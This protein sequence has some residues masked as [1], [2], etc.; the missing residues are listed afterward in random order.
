MIDYTK[1]VDILLKILIKLE[2]L[3]SQLNFQNAEDIMIIE[4]RWKDYILKMLGLH[5]VNYLNHI[6]DT[7][8]PTLS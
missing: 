8:Y 6:M 2:G 3:E 1:K 4:M 5:L 7:Q